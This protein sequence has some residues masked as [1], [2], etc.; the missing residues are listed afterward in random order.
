LGIRELLERRLVRNADVVDEAVDAFQS[1]RG[2]LDH[3]GRP[4]GLTEI[5][6]DAQGGSR[7]APR[8]LDSRT[9]AAADDDPST[10]LREEA[11]RRK[12]DSAG[13]AGDDADTVTQP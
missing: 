3:L 8:P 11:R 10:L 13:R 7:I 9:V 5:G 2:A 1:F 12:P 4:A 6:Y